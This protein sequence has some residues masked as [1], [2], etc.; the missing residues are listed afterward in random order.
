MIGKGL[1]RKAVAVPSA[2][3]VAALL[4]S[5]TAPAAAL[6]CPQG[7]SYPDVPSHASGHSRV[8]ASGSTQMWP[9][10]DGPVK[11]ALASYTGGNFRLT[12]VVE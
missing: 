12:E 5:M 11:S 9:F 10:P 3:A 2:I 6:A 7:R 1:L 8:Q 4:A